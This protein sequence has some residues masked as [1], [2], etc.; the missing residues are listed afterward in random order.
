MPEHPGLDGDSPET[1]IGPDVPNHVPVLDLRNGTQEN[2]K[3]GS[4]L[5]SHA[6]LLAL[7]PSCV[8]QGTCTH[9]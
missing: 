2:P 1:Q 4:S 5:C 6:E 3:W 9:L 7:Q 8:T